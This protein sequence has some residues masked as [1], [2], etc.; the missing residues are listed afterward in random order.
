MASSNR[1]ELSNSDSSGNSGTSS[2][3]NT[4]GVV[5]FPNITEFYD[6]LMDRLQMVLGRFFLKEDFTIFINALPRNHTP[7]TKIFR[8]RFKK[9]SLVYGGIKRQ[10]LL[11]EKTSKKKEFENFDLDEYWSTLHEE[12]NLA[13]ENSAISFN[14]YNELNRGDYE[15]KDIPEIGFDRLSKYFYEDQKLK[16]D[17][18]HLQIA[19]YN[20]LRAYFDIDSYFYLSLPLIQFAEFDGVI[21]IIL[22]KNDYER[23]FHEGI[24]DRKNEKKGFVLAA[25][26]NVIKAFSIEYEGLI[27]DWDIIGAG[28]LQKESLIDALG[29]N[30][31]AENINPILTELEYREY[32]EKHREYFEDRIRYNAQVPLSIREQYR[33]IAIMHI[34]IDS[35]A[36][37]ISAHS[38]TALEWWFRQRA[39]FQSRKEKLSLAHYD[40]QMPIA[41]L[42]DFERPLDK[43]IHPLLGFLHSKGAFWTGLTRDYSFGGQIKSLYNV[44]WQDFINNPLYLGTIAFT[45]GI[46]K[47]NI[48]ITFLNAKSQKADIFF[49]KEVE[50]DGLF[51]QIDLTQFYEATDPEEVE[52]ITDFVRPG[53]RFRAIASQLRKC[54]A[55]FPGGIVG[56]HAF[57]TILENELRNVK[58]Y[59]NQA[60]EQI[61]Q[62]GLTLN[63][64]IETA[65]YVK[66]YKNPEKDPK[67]E[68]ETTEYYKI[69]VWL[70]HPMKVTKKL[71]KLRPERLYSDIMEGEKK[72]FRPKLGGTYQ[73]KVCAAMLFNNSFAKI[74]DQESTRGKQFYPWVKVGS[75][76]NLNYQD[77]DIIEQWEISA[78][79]LL[80]PK[81]KFKSSRDYFDKNYIEKVGYYKKIFHLWIGEN[82]YKIKEVDQLNKEGENISRFRFLEIPPDNK[83]VLSHAKDAGII[84]IIS[85]TTNKINEAYHFW[86]QKWLVDNKKSKTNNFV[87][88]LNYV[89]EISYNSEI[90]AQ[91]EV[92]EKG[93][94]FRKQDKCIDISGYKRI[95]EINLIHK[96]EQEDFSG[97]PAVRYRNHLIF[98]KY[99]CR[100][101]E[102]AKANI[103]E[104]RIGELIEVLSTKICVFD[105]RMAS[106]F[107]GLNKSVFEDQLFCQ[108]HPEN[109]E[110]WEKEKEIGFFRYHFLIIHLSFI[111]S[112]SEPEKG[113]H[114]HEDDIKTFLDQEIIRGQEIP[115]NFI[116]V[117]T[118]GRGRTQWWN[119]LKDFDLKRQ[120]E[121]Q[122]PRAE[123]IMFYNLPYT[124]FVTFRNVESMTM[125]IENA[126]S[127]QDDIELKYRLI[128]VLFGS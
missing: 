100:G 24:I 36:H 118:T 41:L 39:E 99:F 54:K 28:S 79:R 42:E 67:I 61:R 109:K 87:E 77:G 50:L 93:V 15:L 2:K 12:R 21:H 10:R 70:K 124:S 33:Q 53:K 91:L 107:K 71:L 125:A 27:L 64:S 5:A 112:L 123:K 92:N 57:F 127:L 66:E 80:D 121:L 6:E 81:D 115:D 102:L 72:N 120:E 20:I 89:I 128:K 113:K 40:N 83:E 76:P 73:D 63:I 46:L 31:Y 16:A 68:P 48:N 1:K 101:E 19:E 25:A 22:H 14:L 3:D 52:Q 96:P 88:T 122:D 43:E 58:H 51:A 18:T 86:L 90:A 23:I 78:R 114:Y 119:N 56:E 62:E 75:T 17:L 108:F 74:E 49:K 104:D 65:T 30:F 55:F 85:E 82:I 117:I 26:G 59:D 105:N 11:L 7:G 60:L 47:I 95:Q 103:L 110:V 34:L 9:V 44:L 116:V 32:Y 45:E 97:M 84:R 13:S 4:R 8:S 69:G 111:E 106:R 29:K 126:L 98:K 38:L 35:Y 94:F 37:N